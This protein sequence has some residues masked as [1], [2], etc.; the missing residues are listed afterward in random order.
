V[1]IRKQRKALARW[2]DDTR[3]WA[4]NTARDLVLALVS[5]QPIPATPYKV[6]V[7]LGPREQVWAE[8]PLRFLQEHHVDQSM[9]GLPVKPWLVTSD[10]IV[11]RLGDDHL[12]GW[13]WCQIV[14]CRIELT[15]GR[16]RLVLDGVDGNPLTW[17]GP[18]LAPAAVAAAYQL[19]G[20][21]AVL[22]HPG[23]SVLRNQGVRY[24]GSPAACVAA[25]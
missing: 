11:G 23:L 7:V 16:E 4:H 20:P 12:Y 14:G 5:G 1:T 13:R 10:R 15:P 22:E 2:E 25:R 24:R 21:T 8:C 6:G 17:I 9:T 3:R 19:H 18:G